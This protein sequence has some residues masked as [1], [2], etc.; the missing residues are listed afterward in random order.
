MFRSRTSKQEYRTAQ[1]AL[2]LKQYREQ[3]S[4]LAKFVEFSLQIANERH[5]HGLQPVNTFQIPFEHSP[6]LGRAGGA[7]SS[8]IR[9]LPGVTAHQS[10]LTGTLKTGNAI[11]T[12]V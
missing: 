3:A 6:A 12:F 10:V 5:L 9:R 7:G 1:I 2:L 4:A 11:Y 8:T